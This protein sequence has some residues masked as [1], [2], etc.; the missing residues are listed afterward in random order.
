MSLKLLVPYSIGF[1]FCIGVLCFDKAI[2]VILF[3][4]T[5][6]VN[7]GPVFPQTRVKKVNSTVLTLS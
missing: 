1:S 5:L 6:E 3:H 7:V 2:V 4:K